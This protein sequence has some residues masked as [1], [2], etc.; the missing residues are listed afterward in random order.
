VDLAEPVGLLLVS[1]LMYFADD[2][3]GEVVDTLVGALAPGSV[4]VISHPTG[5]FAPE[6]VARAAAVGRASGLTYIA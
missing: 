5:D 6:V 3:V 2:V 4:V 1:V